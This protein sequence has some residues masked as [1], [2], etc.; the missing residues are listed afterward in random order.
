VR[1]EQVKT[2]D[3]MTEVAKKKKVNMEEIPQPTI[4]PW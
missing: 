1:Y 2:F 4:N 3:E